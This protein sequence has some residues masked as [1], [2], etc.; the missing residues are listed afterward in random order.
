MRDEPSWK[1]YDH[2]EPLDFEDVDYYRAKIKKERLTPKII[3][4]YLKQMTYGS[5]RREFW[6]NPAAPAHILAVPD[7][8]LWQS[9]DFEL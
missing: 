3:A 6:I 2:G 8:R 5:L 1:F 9:E 4:G 7:F